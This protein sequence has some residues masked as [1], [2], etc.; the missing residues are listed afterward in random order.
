MSATLSDWFAVRLTPGFHD[1]QR[2]ISLIVLF[3]YALDRSCEH[4]W[5]P[6]KVKRA[7]FSG[8]RLV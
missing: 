4:L 5:S 8:D 2:L 6:C 1:D 7:G 3:D